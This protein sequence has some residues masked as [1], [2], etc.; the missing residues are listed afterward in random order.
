MRV[1]K[2]MR[3]YRDLDAVAAPAGHAHRASR[4][5]PDRHQPPWEAAKTVFA[6]GHSREVDRGRVHAV[7]RRG[8]PETVVVRCLV[9]C[10]TQLSVVLFGAGHTLSRVSSSVAHTV[11]RVV[12][13][14][15]SGIP[16][17]S[18]VGL[19]DSVV[20]RLGTVGGLQFTLHQFSHVFHPSVQVVVT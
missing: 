9:L 4:A 10:W 16:V 3:S 1:I 2:K 7:L 8:E 14:G 20:H 12:S 17:V 6:E 13:G 15:H 19:S 11:S 18:G 5:D